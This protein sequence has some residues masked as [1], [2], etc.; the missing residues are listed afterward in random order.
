MF[1]QDQSRTHRLVP[2]VS[3]SLHPSGCELSWNIEGFWMFETL[4]WEWSCYLSARLI[5]DGRERRR[6]FSSTQLLVKVPVCLGS[7]DDADTATE[8]RTL[9]GTWGR[10]TVELILLL[11]FHWAPFSSDLHPLLTLGDLLIKVLLGRGASAHTFA[12]V[13]SMCVCVCVKS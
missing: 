5:N 11:S 10:S 12:S 4:R 13:F 9:D 7:L 2:P 3:G 8:R 1:F 6:S